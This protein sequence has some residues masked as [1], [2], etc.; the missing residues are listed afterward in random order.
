M[1]AAVEYSG[2]EARHLQGRGGICEI[3]AETLLALGAT[4]PGFHAA[5]ITMQFHAATKEWAVYYFSGG[6]QL[7]G[8]ERPM[9]EDAL[10]QCFFQALEQKQGGRRADEND[11]MRDSEPPPRGRANIE[12]LLG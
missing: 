5:R 11:W 7:V 12:D 8:A 2:V 1:S 9:L 3:A 6:T 4:T 10:E